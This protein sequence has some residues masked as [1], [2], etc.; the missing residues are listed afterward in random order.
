M[1]EDVSAA[2]RLEADYVVIVGEDEL[3]KGAVILRNMETK[4]QQEIPVDR[5]VQSLVDLFE[6]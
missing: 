5:L 1:H 2:N 3:E 6:E 4:D